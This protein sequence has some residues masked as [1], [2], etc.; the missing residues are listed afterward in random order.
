MP[1]QSLE[2]DALILLKRLPT[3]SF[4][5]FTAFT[6]GHG[7]IHIQYR[8]ARTAPAI[9]LFDTV[10]LQLDSSNQGRTWFVRE[11]RLLARPAGIGR[12]YDALRFASALATLIARNT[13]HEDSRDAVAHLLSGA[14]AAFA[15]GTR[16]DIVYF[17]S[18]YR[19]ARHEGYPMKEQ[20]FPTLPAADR[21]EVAALL[22]QPLAGQTTTVAVVARLQRQMEDYLRSHTEVLVD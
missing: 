12:S 4:Q 7:L 16:P 6:A 8:A 9:D 18:L 21:T 2:T 22:N 17:K 13:V 3:D 20:W 11:A 15:A 19:F 10:A 1:A 5:G 14:F